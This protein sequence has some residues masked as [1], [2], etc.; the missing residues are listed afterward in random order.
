MPIMVVKDSSE[1]ERYMQELREATRM[2]AE[3]NAVEEAM[4]RPQ[5]DTTTLPQVMVRAEE[6]YQW[7]TD[8]YTSAL[9]LPIGPENTM[10]VTNKPGLAGLLDTRNKQLLTVLSRSCDYM[11]AIIEHVTALRVLIEGRHS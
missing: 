11:Q 2:A 1:K 10:P 9:D 4:L 7:I 6:L 5:D 8:L 3:K